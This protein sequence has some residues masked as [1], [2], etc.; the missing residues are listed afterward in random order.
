[1]NFHAYHGVLEEEKKYGNHFLVSLSVTF[2]TSKAG[3]SDR[4]EDTLNYQE[5]YDIVHDQ[6]KQRSDLIEHV[7]Q[8]IYDKVAVSFPFLEKIEL[9]LT[10]LNPPL[11]GNVEGVTIQL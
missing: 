8:R 11:G 4:L 5:L 3:A 10:K 6:M 1:M 9:S 7:A 2:D